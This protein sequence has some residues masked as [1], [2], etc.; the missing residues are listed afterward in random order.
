MTETKKSEGRSKTHFE[1]Q[2]ELVLLN[3]EQLKVLSSAAAGEVF[4]CLA[5]DQAYAIRE[6]SKEVGKS[7]ASVGAHINNLVEAGLVIQ[8]ASRKRR[9]RTEALYTK[10]GLITRLPIG[11][12]SDETI[13]EYYVRFRSVLSLIDREQRA[14]WKAVQVDPI[15]KDFGRFSQ[16]N[17]WLTPEQ[18][19]TLKQAIADL[20]ALAH[21]LNEKDPEKRADTSTVRV[22]LSSAFFPT[23]VESRAR[24]EKPKK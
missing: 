21:E 2:V 24:L 17:V 5:E 16:S 14:F 1:G 19:R 4:N 3:L 23:L 22:H 20:H 10:K 13:E 15:L 12:Q 18:A 7:S 9:S 6:I 11:E 8:V